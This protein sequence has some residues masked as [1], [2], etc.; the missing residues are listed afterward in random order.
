MLGRL[1]SVGYVPIPATV[2]R[3][4]QQYVGTYHY[5]GQELQMPTI[6]DILVAREFN[7]S[8]ESGCRLT[9]SQDSQRRRRFVC[10]P[11]VMYQ[12]VVRKTKCG[13]HSSEMFHHQHHHLTKPSARL[14]ESLQSLSGF[15]G[16][17]VAL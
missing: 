10:L 5:V 8:K 6:M 1:G 14:A 11:L 7:D 15:A 16:I 2:A 9:L 3:L 12:K 17:S 4:W 13:T